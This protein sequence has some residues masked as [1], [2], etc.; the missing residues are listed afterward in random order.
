M[1]FD[2][3]GGR[4]HWDGTEVTTVWL[5]QPFSF[6]SD[7]LFFE[8]LFGCLSHLGRLWPKWLNGKTIPHLWIRR[9]KPMKQLQFFNGYFNC[10]TFTLIRIQVLAVCDSHLWAWVCILTFVQIAYLNIELYGTT[11]FSPTCNYII[12]WSWDLIMSFVY[13]LATICLGTRCL[14]TVLEL[15]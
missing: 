7:I 1:Y 2:N 10:A 14:C 8:A 6:Y 9:Q 15:P 13:N 12:M 3:L 11:L 5:Q 4:R